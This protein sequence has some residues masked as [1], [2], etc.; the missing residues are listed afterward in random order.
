MLLRYVVDFIDYMLVYS[1][2]LDEHK[3][4]TRNTLIQLLEQSFLGSW[5][6]HC[7][8]SCTALSGS[9]L[10]QSPESWL[11]YTPYFTYFSHKI[12]VA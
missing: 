10:L 6:N 12:S 11:S 5:I 7:S 3:D 1:Y 8:L 4:D 2:S 9:N